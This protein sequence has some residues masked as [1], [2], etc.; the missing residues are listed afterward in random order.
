MAENTR[1]EWAHHTFSPWIGC[2]RVSP[3][4]EHCYAEQWAKRYRFVEWGATGER[5]KTSA[6]YWRQPLRWDKQA[7]ALGI[8][9]RV[10]C[11]SMADVFDAKAPEVVRRALWEL[12]SQTSNLDW[13]VLTKRPENF[14]SMLPAD[15]GEG[16]P[17]VWLGVTAENQECANTRIPLLKAQAAKRRF[18][19]AEPLLGPIN[20]FRA[21]A[22]NG[23]DWLIVG[24]ESSRHARP[25][26]PEWVRALRDQCGKIAI[27]FFFKQW[28]EWMLTGK[29]YVRTGK[30]SAGRLLDNEIWDE[31]PA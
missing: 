17:N 19:S 16:Y 12:I 11:A 24:G 7:I 3:G 4:C 2:Q 30:A 27:P 5:V 14:G 25:M 21:S 31:C 28:G 9:Y 20:L 18:V 13:L 8:R 1:I 26:N 23:I 22:D 6:S 29:G 15:W 10:F